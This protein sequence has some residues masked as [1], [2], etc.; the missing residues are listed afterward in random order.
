MDPEYDWL[1]LKKGEEVVWAD[2]PHEYSLV[3]ALAI[4]LPLCLVLVGIPIVAS[5]VL[6][7]RNTN[8]V[9]T[10]DALYA[11]TGVLSRNVQRIEFGKV[12]DTSYQ[13]SVLGTRF[14]YGT[15]DLSTAG[16]GGVEMQ[17]R[18]IAEPREVQSLINERLGG[19]ETG[20]ED[21]ADVLDDILAEL[22]AIRTA[23]EGEERDAADAPER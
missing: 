21:A 11:K 20:D 22:K 13:Q 6:Q 23:V 19:D 1:S 8:Y 16:G 14:G 12:Q 9:V 3:P 18:N 4:G 10:T 5:A 15:V 17:F 7:H 2:T